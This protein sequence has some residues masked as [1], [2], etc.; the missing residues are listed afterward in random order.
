MLGSI[1]LMT[2]WPAPLFFVFREV[3]RQDSF[4]SLF[5][6]QKKSHVGVCFILLLLVNLNAIDNSFHV[7]FRGE[8]VNGLWTLKREVG[9][10]IN[11]SL[12]CGPCFLASWWL[13]ES[14]RFPWTHSSSGCMVLPTTL[15]QNSRGAR[16]HSD[17]TWNRFKLSVP[18]SWKVQGSW[19]FE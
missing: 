10:T 8:L 17:R 4:S 15:G 3:G 7:K 13:W 19:R 14:F 11:K 6:V 12:Y 9:P 18:R 16:D 5:L 1:K 2:Y